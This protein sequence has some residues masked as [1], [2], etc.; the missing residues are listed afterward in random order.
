MNNN[1]NPLIG[2]NNTFGT[3]ATIAGLGTAGA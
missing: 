3:A 1:T 2:I